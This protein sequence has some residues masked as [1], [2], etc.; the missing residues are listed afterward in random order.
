MSE[1]PYN[2]AIPFATVYFRTMKGER[3]M[4]KLVLMLL[5]LSLLSFGVLIPQ[6]PVAACYG[7][8]CRGKD[9]AVEK[10]SQGR[11]CSATAYTVYGGIQK[12]GRMAQ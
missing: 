3:K 9:P 12:A 4:R 10:D 8:S 7:T 1:R 2:L 11:L 5:A 6:A